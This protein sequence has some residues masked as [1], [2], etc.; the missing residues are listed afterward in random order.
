MARREDQPAPP[1]AGEPAIETEGE[2]E[3]TREFTTPELARAAREPPPGAPRPLG[4]DDDWRSR[5]AG[6]ARPASPG[7][8]S[9]QRG[10]DEREEESLRRQAEAGLPDDERGD[11]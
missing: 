1:K 9:G 7:P 8:A 11:R 4:E 2:G 10:R 6:T 3:G 5:A